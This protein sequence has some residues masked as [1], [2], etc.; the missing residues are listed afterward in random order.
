MIKKATY[1]IFTILTSIWILWT[2]LTELTSIIARIRALREYY[3]TSYIDDGVNLLLLLPLVLIFIYFIIYLFNLSRKGI[4]Y[5]KDKKWD[6]LILVS[7][8]LIGSIFIHS[9]VAGVENPYRYWIINTYL[10]PMVFFLLYQRF[11]LKYL[12][13][14]K[15]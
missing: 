12:E 6:K 7:F 5:Y 15:Q 13:E 10:C 14:I 2:T 1:Y 4:D 3:F 9:F 8:F 11:N